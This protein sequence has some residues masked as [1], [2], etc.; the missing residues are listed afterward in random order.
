MNTAPAVRFFERPYPSAN[1]VLL[2]G[3][4]PILVDSGF[5][6]DVTD[7]EGWLAAQGT[8]A[9]DLALLVSTHH[10]CDHV[11]GNHALRARYGLDIAA[12]AWE[13]QAV[14]RR[15]PEACAAR[16]LAQPVEAYRVARLL[17]GGE[18]LDT[19]AQAWQVI[20]TPGHTLG[21]IILYQQEHRIGICG[22]A[23]LP[24]DVGWLNYHRE[25]LSAIDRALE[26]LEVLSALNLAVAYPG[27]GP[28]IKDVPA[29]I[30]FARAR[31]Q[32]W[33]DDPQKVGWHACKRIFAYALMIEGA[34]SPDDVQQ[35]LLSSPWLLDHAR[36][37]FRVTPEAFS[38]QLVA[39]MVRSGAAQWQGGRL[40]VTG[41]HRLPLRDWA[42]TPTRVQDWSQ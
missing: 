24:G 9:S 42:T 13:G 6:S 20:H 40:T 26:S 4:K 38:A 28:A 32:K 27:H 21:H 16:W 10:H 22:D 8:P 31:L 41:P 35:Y 5:G 39:E 12:H 29:A 7:L 3:P 30:A 17:R 15:D 1:S 19:G 25:G 37:T 36:D 11:G 33:L 23:L 18:T 2:T 34:K 14:N